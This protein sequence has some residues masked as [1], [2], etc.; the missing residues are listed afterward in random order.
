MKIDKLSLMVG[1]PIPIQE[2]G[3]VLNQPKIRDVGMLGEEKFYQSLSYF[4]INKNKINVEINIS[5][6]DLFIL[7]LTQSQELQQGVADL[8]TLII[9]D[10]ESVKFFDG[11]ILIKTSGHE[12]IIDEPKFLI[13]R[14]A[15]IEIFCL[16]EIESSDLNPANRAAQKIAEKLRKRK[17]ALGS[18]SS[19]GNEGIYTT[20]I[21]IL[22]I[23]SNTLNL[24]DCLNLT[25][26]QI[27]DLFKRFNLFFEF[28]IQMQSMLQGAQDIEPTEWTKQF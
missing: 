10:L 11:F 17:E 19:K 8:F 6:F 7:S 15:L 21:S 13:I 28:N 3:I 12:C 23:G 20:L 1:A 18:K 26:F 16:K 25:I 5:D 4:L 24:E 2:L 9:E 27:Q 22:V 14:E